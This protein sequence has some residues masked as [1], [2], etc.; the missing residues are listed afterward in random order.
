MPYLALLRAGLEEH[1]PSHQGSKR[2]ERP[3]VRLL[4]LESARAGQVPEAQPCS[5]SLLSPALAR[6]AR[7]YD[8]S[9]LQGRVGPRLTAGLVY[10]CC[11]GLK[12]CGCDCPNQAA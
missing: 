10:T 7:E 11:K 5:L 9:R 4:G 12:Q 3:L 1:P 8:I 2:K 6:G